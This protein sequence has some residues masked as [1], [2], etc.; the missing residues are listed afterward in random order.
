MSAVT[1]TAKTSEGSATSIQNNV[2]KDNDQYG[3]ILQNQPAM[4]PPTGS[5]T[6]SGNKVG[7]TDTVA[8]G[9]FGIDASSFA[10]Q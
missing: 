10:T 8:A 3:I 9:T 7:D 6:F 1:A 2:I 4:A 5:N